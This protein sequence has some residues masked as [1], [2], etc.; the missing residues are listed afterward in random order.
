MGDELQRS[1][2]IKERELFIMT[3]KEIRQ[4]VVATAKK[5]L[6]CKESDGN[7]WQF[8]DR[9]NSFSPFIQPFAPES[10][11]DLFRRVVRDLRFGGC[12][13][14]RTDRHHAG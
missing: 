11:D 8:I 2:H 7:H 4:K 10:P 9:Y 12:D 6:G 1:P 13:R 5:Y 3:E 14:V